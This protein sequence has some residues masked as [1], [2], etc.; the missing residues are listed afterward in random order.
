M[1]GAP[2]FAKGHLRKYAELV[3]VDADDLFSDY[4]QLTRSA[5]LPPVVAASRSKARKELTP[6]PWIAA[7]IVILAA[8]IGYWWLISG[9]VVVVPPLDA[10]PQ[11]Q[12]PEP[13][14]ATSSDTDSL[15]TTAGVPDDEPAPL[16][17]PVREAEP[18]VQDPPD[19][20]LRLSL[21]FTGD[22]WTEITDA[23][24][25]RLFFDMGRSGRTVELT[26]RPPLRAL[27][28]NADNVGI[29]VNGNNFSIPAS[30]RDNRTARLAILNP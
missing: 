27:F 30:A 3:G 10:V 6:G 28:G 1:L 22:C 20:Q 15:V 26:G 25:R 8:A 14:S 12:Q 2:V 19:G 29:R 9:D 21:T 11:E 18:A 7:I 16:P 13:S 23:D 17:E 5:S 4:Y 24:G